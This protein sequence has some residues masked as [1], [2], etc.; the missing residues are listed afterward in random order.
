MWHEDWT[1][2]DVWC[3]RYIVSASIRSGLGYRCE[4]YN[5]FA[6]G[7]EAIHLP[8]PHWSLL[9]RQWLQSVAGPKHGCCGHEQLGKERLASI[10]TCLAENF[11]CNS[12][13]LPYRLV[14]ALEMATAVQ[15]PLPPPDMSSPSS[16]F[17]YFSFISSIS[18]QHTSA[19]RKTQQVKRSAK[20]DS[21][22]Y[23]HLPWISP[24]QL[25]AASSCSTCSS[26]ARGATALQPWMMVYGARHALVVKVHDA[27]AHRCSRRT[28]RHGTASA[29][30]RDRSCGCGT[31]GKP[32]CHPLLLL[33]CL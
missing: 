33:L 18:E 2:E 29:R 17:V 13:V 1:Y 6:N 26:P 21:H 11:I 23:L 8:V 32:N 4:F 30:S 7:E 25:V 28:T 10:S 20:T 22:P 27:R 31:P 24:L 19:E 5:V 9:R 14:M 15:T 12:G 3:S 16:S